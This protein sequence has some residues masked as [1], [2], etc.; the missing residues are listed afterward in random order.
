MTA[1]P[2]HHGIYP[3]KR[4]KGAVRAASSWW[5]STPQR[6]FGAWGPSSGNPL[7]LGSGMRGKEGGS[8]SRASPGRPMHPL[9]GG[10]G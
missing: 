9:R 7:S 4:G 2:C 6:L 3:G 1:P 5:A 8:W 10:L